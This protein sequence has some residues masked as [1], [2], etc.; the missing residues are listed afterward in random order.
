M[1]CRRSRVQISSGP[2]FYFYPI[3]RQVIMKTLII[4]E[5]PSVARDLAR[6]LGSFEQKDNYM[7]SEKYII[8]WAYG[9]LLELAEPEDY[10]KAYKFWT[11][12]KLPI[13]P[14]KFE[15]KAIGKSEK[16]LKNI[17]SLMKKKKLS[18]L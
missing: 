16:Q 13:L 7:L 6:S 8:T 11:L 15:W 4:T 3:S 2:P 1:A 5:K 12:Q 17:L 10:D 18:Q 14:K 9:H